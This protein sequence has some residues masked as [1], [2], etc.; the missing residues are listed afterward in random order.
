LERKR[1]WQDD[2]G[3]YYARDDRA[4]RRQVRKWERRYGPFEERFRWRLT[5]RLSRGMA[6]RECLICGGPFMPEARSGQGPMLCSQGCEAE[7]RKRERWIK[8]AVEK[9]RHII[10]R[11]VW[12]WLR[13]RKPVVRCEHCK[14]VF[15]PKGKG[16]PPT[17]C[18]KACRQAAY[19]RRTKQATRHLKPL[20]DFVCIGCGE[21]F[22][23]RRKDRAYCTKACYLKHCDRIKYFRRTGRTRPLT[24]GACGKLLPRAPKRW[25][26]YCNGTCEMR[27]L[28]RRKKVGKGVV[29]AGVL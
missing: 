26:Y 17:Y 9:Y 19:K 18:G 1:Y 10:D 28:R 23:A 29:A 13:D 24:C 4:A 21:G 5:F 27:A 11:E 8:E 16:R 2:P 20:L 25:K 3:K 22:R 12:F 7:R 6:V 14:T 15:I